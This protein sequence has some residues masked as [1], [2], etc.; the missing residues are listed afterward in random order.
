[1]ARERRGQAAGLWALVIV[2]AIQGLTPDARSLASSWTFDRLDDLVVNSESADRGVAPFPGSD[3]LGD[4]DRNEAPT[5]STVAGMPEGSSTIGRRRAFAPSVNLLPAPEAYR[6]I[7][8]PPRGLDGTSHLTLH[9]RRPALA[10]L[11]RL[12]C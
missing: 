5:V 12:T 11:C 8:D 10:V 1:M 4:P 6:P 2:S 9:A 7:A 3:R